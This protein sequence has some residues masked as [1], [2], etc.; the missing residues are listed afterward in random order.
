MTVAEKEAFEKRIADLEFKVDAVE[1]FTGFG[2]GGKWMKQLF[3][4]RLFGQLIGQSISLVLY[5]LVI[6]GIVKC[7]GKV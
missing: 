2:K 5:T 4:T 7:S 1:L 6:Y 3:Y